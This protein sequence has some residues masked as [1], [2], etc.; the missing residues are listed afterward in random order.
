MIFLI[1]NEKQRPPI[2]VDCPPEFADIIRECWD[3]SPAKRPSAN[4]VSAI[5]EDKRPKLEVPKLRFG[6]RRSML[7]IFNKAF[8]ADALYKEYFEVDR[9]A[10]LSDHIKSDR[11]RIETLHNPPPLPSNTK[12][13]FDLPPEVTIVHLTPKSQGSHRLVSTS[14]DDRLFTR[15]L[16]YFERFY[17]HSTNTSQAYLNG[18][19][20]ILNPKLEEQF[21][22]TDAMFSKKYQGLQEIEV[23]K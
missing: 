9:A 6:S 13:N 22:S 21:A 17:A 20:V 19:D 8:F 12:I 3:D 15:V 23:C 7:K 11:I 2:P 10:L 5:L 1:K 14:Y 4:T 16:E 18:I